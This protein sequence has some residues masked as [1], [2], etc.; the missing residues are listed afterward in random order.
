MEKTEASGRTVEDALNKALAQLGANRDEV[1]FVVLDEGKAGGLL[2]FGRGRE[3]VVRVERKAASGDAPRGDR[4]GRPPR[5]DRG[6][7]GG[8]RDGDR[9]RGNGRGG[10]GG[11]G[12][13]RGE[14][15]SSSSSSGS[16]GGRSSSRSGFEQSGPE[17]TESDFFGEGDQSQRQSQ[18]S[19]PPPRGRSEGGDRQ[20]SERPPRD[21]DDGGDHDGRAEVA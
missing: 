3:A 19:G 8:G 4:G 16:S 15:S 14:R 6:G 12:R 18:R 7:G 10:G 1:E 2:S 13:G 21:R 17:L 20:R 9:G 5:S 11:G